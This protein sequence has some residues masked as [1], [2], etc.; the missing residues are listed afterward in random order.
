MHQI[1]PSSMPSM[2]FFSVLSWVDCL[3]GLDGD[4]SPSNLG[5]SKIEG[6]WS[7]SS[8]SSIFS[9]F[10]FKS[11]LSS[12]EIS[13]TITYLSLYNLLS[14]DMTC[15]LLII[16]KFQDSTIKNILQTIGQLRLGFA[17]ARRLCSRVMI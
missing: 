15:F 7:S 4:F 5:T 14:N 13:V 8:Y 12:H 17:R 11:S 2:L 10:F 6:E 1:T 9:S 3:S 16:E